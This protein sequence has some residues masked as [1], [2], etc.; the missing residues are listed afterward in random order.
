MPE[1]HNQVASLTSHNGARW[2]WF[3][4]G[5][6]WV[7]CPAVACS[8]TE[9]RLHLSATVLRSTTLASWPGHSPQPLC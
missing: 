9:A 4:C 6:W 2:L 7:S 5:E 8:C 3:L 1:G